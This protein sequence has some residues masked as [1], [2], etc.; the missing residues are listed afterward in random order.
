MKGKGN[1]YEPNLREEVRNYYVSRID[2]S[3]WIK[4]QNVIL[5]SICYGLT[6]N[7]QAVQFKDVI[8]LPRHEAQPTWE[9]DAA[10]DRNGMVQYCGSLG[11]IFWFEK[12]HQYHNL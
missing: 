12:A 1:W 7:N 5:S 3:T 11:R 8:G 2:K 9:K 10:Q 6:V 4:L